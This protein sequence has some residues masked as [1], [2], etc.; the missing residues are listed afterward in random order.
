VLGEHAS[1]VEQN[2]KKERCTKGMISRHQLALQSNKV[3][4]IIG[5][6]MELVGGVN[7]SRSQDEEFVASSRR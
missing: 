6:S 3:K 5:Q 2:L 4:A 1:E 7:D